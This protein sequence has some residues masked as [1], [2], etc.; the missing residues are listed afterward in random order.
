MLISSPLDSPRDIGCSC[1]KATLEKAASPRQIAKA[2]RQ[3]LLGPSSRRLAPT[4]SS[5]GQANRWRPKPQ[6]RIG[7]MVTL[8]LPAIHGRLF[9]FRNSKVFHLSIAVDITSIG[10]MSTI[11]PV[12]FSIFSLTCAIGNSSSS[13]PTKMA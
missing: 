13:D 2:G 5:N 8:P 7:S 11:V 10:F 1:A 12:S 4:R 9:F 3:D 6:C